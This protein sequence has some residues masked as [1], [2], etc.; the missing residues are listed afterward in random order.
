MPPFEQDH[1][2]SR[3]LLTKLVQKCRRRGT[4]HLTGPHGDQ[5]DGAEELTGEHALTYLDRT[6][7]DRMIPGLREQW[8]GAW[9]EPS[10]ADIEVAA[11]HAACLAAIRR[12]GGT[13]FRFTV[14]IEE[15][16]E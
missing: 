15:E 10:C 8:T 13:V 12:E 6:E 16:D 1:A 4:V 3:P 9:F 5:I 7:L 11:F 14:P 2:W